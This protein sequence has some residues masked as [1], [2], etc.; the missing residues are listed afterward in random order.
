ML[1]LKDRIDLLETHLKAN[2]PQ[3]SSYSDLPFAILR[4]DP[5]EEWTVRRE[6]KLLATRLADAGKTVH[7][8][9]L[10]DLLWESVDET[11]GMDA[12]VKWE[13][14]NGFRAAE[15]QV[16]AYLTDPDWFPL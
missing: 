11:E 6:A 2:P 4:Y 3:I 8:I 15:E 12:L 1:S 9:S 5:W 7:T 14:D 16:T 13:R 10:A